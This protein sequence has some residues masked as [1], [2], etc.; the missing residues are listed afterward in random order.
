M[1]HVASVFLVAEWLKVVQA[2]NS[3]QT[4]GKHGGKLKDFCASCSLRCY[5]EWTWHGWNYLK[6]W[7]EE[8]IDHLPAFLLVEGIEEDMG[9]FHSPVSFT[10][11]E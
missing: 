10:D 1:G 8:G 4:C 3:W 7:T 6:F 11:Q 2:A 5:L 9:R